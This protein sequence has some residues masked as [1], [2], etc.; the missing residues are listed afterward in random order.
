ML[1]GA[2]LY[3]KRKLENLD[4]RPLS[5]FAAVR[6]GDSTAAGFGFSMGKALALVG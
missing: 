2:V 3:E 5:A 1:V 6:E 4:N